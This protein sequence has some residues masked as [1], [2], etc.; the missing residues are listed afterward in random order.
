MV[1]VVLIGDWKNAKR[2]FIDNDCESGVLNSVISVRS[3]TALHVAAV[4]FIF[5]CFFRYACETQT[6]FHHCHQKVGSV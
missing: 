4:N 6:I 3:I 5:V 2:L 1:I